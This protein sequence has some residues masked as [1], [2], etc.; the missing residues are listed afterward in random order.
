MKAFYTALAI[1]AAAALIHMGFHF[2]NFKP[3]ELEIPLGLPAIHWPENNPYSKKKAE[4]GKLLYFDK[5]LSSDGTIACVNCH[6]I[7]R[8]FTDNR[9]VSIGIK[10]QH[11][12]RHA[13]TIINTAY[14]K[15]FFWDG[16]AKSL[17]DQAKGPISNPK[18]MTVIDNEHEALQL[19]HE[20]IRGIKGY[21][22]L[23]KEV[24]G[25]EDCSIDD[26]AKAIATFERTILS[27]NSAYDRYKA[28]DHSAMTK[29]QIHGMHVFK[30][31]GC[32]VC[33]SGPNF[34]DNAFMNIGVGMDAEN[35]DLGRY[36]I[37]KIKSDYGA[38]KVPTLREVT[39]TYPYMHDGSIRTLEEVIDFY[40]KGGIP[41][42]N[43]H[44]TI[45]PLHLSKED[46]QA[47][48]SFLIALDGEGWQHF[49]EANKF[50]E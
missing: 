27:G 46:K 3:E 35:P 14:Q 8:A 20:R 22:K 1:V 25:S 26:I 15:R 44:P 9:R 31:S 6:S 33:H 4:L 45:K 34:T 19:C 47:L 38:F 36:E 18:E 37:T 43:L 28:G 2:F 41:N 16:R 50:P 32:A 17:E 13:P 30:R 49:R 10:G 7:P 48:V 12:T 39:K 23:F 40:D 11:G 21:R 24:F 29:E 5:R 42:Q